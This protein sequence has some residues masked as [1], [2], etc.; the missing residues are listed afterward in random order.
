MSSCPDLN[1]DQPSIVCLV[2]G[3][4]EARKFIL[5]LCRYLQKRGDMILLLYIFKRLRFFILVYGQVFVSQSTN[6]PH[7]YSPSS[8]DC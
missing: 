6:H 2:I 1:I 5:N 3:S 7:S 8:T 4:S